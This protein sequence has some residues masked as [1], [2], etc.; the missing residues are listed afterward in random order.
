MDLIKF[1]G[2]EA[3]IGAYLWQVIIEET[4]HGSTVL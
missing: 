2:V 3:E 4:T 1:F